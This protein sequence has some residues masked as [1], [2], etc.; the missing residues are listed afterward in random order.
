MYDVVFFGGG[1][2]SGWVFMQLCEK[3][4]YDTTN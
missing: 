4:N 1:E 2:K 3:Y